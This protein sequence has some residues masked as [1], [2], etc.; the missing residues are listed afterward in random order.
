MNFAAGQLDYLVIIIIY[1]YAYSNKS[2][3][4]KLSKFNNSLKRQFHSTSKFKNL[5]RS[6]FKLSVSNRRS[7]NS[8]KN[9]EKQHVLCYFW[10]NEYD[11]TIKQRMASGL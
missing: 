5:N 3:T 1:N 6:N 8:F 2:F 10:N 9:G 11:A 7:I 4:D